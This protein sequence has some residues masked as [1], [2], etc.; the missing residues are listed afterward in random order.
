MTI[1]EGRVQVTEDEQTLVRDKHSQAGGYV[2][3][4]LISPA[5]MTVPSM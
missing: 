3:F 2:M 5:S 1:H 4:D